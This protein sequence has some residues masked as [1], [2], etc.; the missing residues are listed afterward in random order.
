MGVMAMDKS[1]PQITHPLAPLSAAEIEAA[2]DL[3]RTADKLGSEPVFTSIGL[4]EPD[5]L[6]VWNYRPGQPF[7]RVARVL[8]T[9]EHP[10]GGFDAEI[11]LV[12]STVS[13]KRVEGA[14]T[15]IGLVELLRVIGITKEDQHWRAAVRNRGIDIEQVQID[16]WPGAGH[17]PT[18]VNPNHRL[19]RAISFVREDATDNGYARPIQGLIAIVDLT[20]GRVAHLQDDGEVALPSESGRYDAEHQPRWREDL[21]PIAITQ[22]EGP[23]FRVDGYAVEWQGFALRLS[24]HPSQGLVLHQLSYREPGGQPRPILY[25]AALSDMIVPYGDPSSMHGWKHAMDAS[26]YSLGTLANSLVLGCDCL[27]EIHYFDAYTLRWDGKA[28]CIKNAICM[29]EEDYGVLWKHYDPLSETT[30]VRRQ[31]RLVISS[32]FTV[33]NYDYGFFWYLYL[34]GTVQME[35]K[36]TG[37]VGVSA[38][39][40]GSDQ[41]ECAPNIAPG[42]AS[43]VHQHLF[44]FRLDFAL[45]GL[46]NSVYEVDVEPLPAG[47]DNPYGS[48][49]RTR[50]TP[51]RNEG[52]ARR[53]ISPERSRVWKVVNPD[54]RNRLGEP[55][56]YKLLPGSTPTIFA[57]PD[58][59]IGKR[60]GFARHNLWAT[61]FDPD[62][63][64]ATGT[65]SYQG[66]GEDGLPAYS[67]GR[68]LENTDIVLWHSLGLTHVPRP[69]D[70][71]VMP[72]EYCGFSLVP[73]GFFDCNPTLDVP[74]G[75]ATCED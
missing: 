13:L 49:F 17:L 36:L 23:S 35:I 25:R 60:G 10:D 29:H 16:P 12:A 7:P 11:D 44:C 58:S 68:S 69:E 47:A 19:M 42:L 59:F 45:D 43:P 3:V 37:I 61:A 52:E 53:N 21:Q 50:T 31:R 20:E 15:P 34:D 26:E 74:P 38:V 75:S 41:P 51:L 67:R 33:G 40:E 54:S 30:E 6:L 32:F 73:T 71:P 46:N 62:E 65:Y 64:N 24:M 2:A 4:V 66:S 18:S 14:Q 8:G 72:V 27:G 1:S 5:K 39:P 48:G 28:H 56:A 57:P 9:D 55:V 22:P 70:W 63:L